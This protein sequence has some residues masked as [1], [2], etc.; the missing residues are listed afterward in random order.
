VPSN[1]TEAEVTVA[2]QLVKAMVK[3]VGAAVEPAPLKA[4]LEICPIDTV[5]GVLTLFVTVHEASVMEPVKLSVPSAENAGRE[6]KHDAIAD[7]N[8]IFL[9][10]T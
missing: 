7:A 1:F 8:K 9:M 2:G 10:A 5:S 4:V 6:N 3:R